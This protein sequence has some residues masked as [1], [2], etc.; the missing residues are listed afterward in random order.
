M[1]SRLLLLATMLDP[2]TSLG[3]AVNIAQVAE[4]SVKICNEARDIRRSVSVS[5]TRHAHLANTTHELL[6]RSRKLARETQEQVDEIKKVN[7]CA[8]TTT[9][10]SGT[11]GVDSGPSLNLL[12]GRCEQIVKDLESELQYVRSQN[13]DGVIGSLK[14]AVKTRQ[15]E[16]RFQVIEKRAHDIRE[17]MILQVVSIIKYAHILARVNKDVDLWQTRCIW[18]AIDDTR[19]CRRQRPA[20]A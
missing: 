10:M 8:S 1:P 9:Q 18:L 2:I 19:S 13:P 14:Q 12:A 5:S 7:P 16:P 20:V 3:L 6:S 17:E 4:L 11:H 15:R